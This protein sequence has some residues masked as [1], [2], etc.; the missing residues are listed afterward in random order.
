MSVHRFTFDH[1]LS[2]DYLVLPFL[3]QFFTSA[4][5]LQTFKVL[6]SE[7]NAWTSLGQVDPSSL[8]VDQLSTEYS[9]LSLFNCLFEKGILREDGS[10]KPCF[11]TQV[12]CTP[13]C[14]GTLNLI[15]TDPLADLSSFDTPFLV[16]DELKVCLLDPTSESL[17]Y[18]P[19]D[20]LRKE[21][22]FHILFH[23]VMGGHINQFDENIGPYFDAVKAFSR[24]FLRVVKKNE[25][26][27]SIRS[28]VFRVLNLN[29]SLAPLFPSL[30]PQNFLLLFV[31]P[32]GRQVMT[33]YHAAPSY[34][35]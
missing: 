35:L 3:Q 8:V 15:C 10:I 21:A 25:S 24:T 29:S 30:H 27:I 28:L 20:T 34:Y 33:W 19:K 7:T 2:S 13:D 23:L 14:L 1:H 11:D 6:F 5:V 31:D 12:S 32:I 22:L 16:S 18:F 4:E 17:G 9:D 26:S